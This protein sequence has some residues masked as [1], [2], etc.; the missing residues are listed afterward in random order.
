LTARSIKWAGTWLE[1][2]PSG[3]CKLFRSVN[4]ATEYP[5]VATKSEYAKLK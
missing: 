3:A 4:A 2:T 1:L 5:L